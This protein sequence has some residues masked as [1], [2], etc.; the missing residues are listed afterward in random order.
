VDLGKSVLLYKTK[1]TQLGKKFVALAGTGTETGTANIKVAQT[2]GWK[3]GQYVMG[4]FD[5]GASINPAIRS[6]LIQ[7]AMDQQ[8]F[9]SGLVSGF[10]AWVAVN[11]LF[12]PLTVYNTGSAYVT[13]KTIA[14]VDKRDAGVARL[15]KA[16]GFKV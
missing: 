13:P 4:T 9:M 11:R 10:H 2:L 16:Y 14:A 1:L 6:G 15:R 12:T 3:P 8:F 7:F 5:T